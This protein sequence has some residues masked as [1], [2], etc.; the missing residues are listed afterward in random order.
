MCSSVDGIVGINT[1]SIF[2]VPISRSRR[3]KS[4]RSITSVGLLNEI[5]WKRTTSHA[6]SKQEA[7]HFGRIHDCLFFSRRG[8]KPTFNTQW[9]PYDEE[10][11]ES[12][13]RY[14]EEGTGRRYRAAA[15]RVGGRA[16]RTGP[17]GA[18]CHEY[19]TMCPDTNPKA[20][21]LTLHAHRKGHTTARFG[22]LPPQPVPTKALVEFSPVYG[23]DSI[24]N[25]CNHQS[26]SCLSILHTR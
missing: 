21:S 10:Y 14:V 18:A 11:I 22:T 20:L 13:Y 26:M 25:N 5:I 16:S 12:H 19:A 9:T 4:C 8:P 7:T 15:A 24:A 3:S 1:R 2:C 23:E 17:E 6:D